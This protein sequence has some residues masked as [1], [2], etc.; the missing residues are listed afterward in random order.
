MGQSNQIKSEV[1]FKFRAV[2]YLKMNKISF[3]KK[4]TVNGRKFEDVVNPEIKIQNGLVLPEFTTNAFEIA[5]KWLNDQSE[6]LSN[7][8]IEKD[9]NCIL[10]WE[11][12]SIT[13][14]PKDQ[15]EITLSLVKKVDKKETLT[16]ILV[17]NVS[18]LDQDFLD[19]FEHAYLQ[20]KDSLKGIPKDQQILIVMKSMGVSAMAASNAFQHMIDYSEKIK[21]KNLLEEQQ[22]NLFYPK[23]D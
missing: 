16:E 22:K 5:D 4:I 1:I 2:S 19:F 3:K 12:V 20:M 23:H 18:G 9:L 6:I 11:V 21:T 17:R 10:D 7:I 14:F 13:N 8:I 15:S